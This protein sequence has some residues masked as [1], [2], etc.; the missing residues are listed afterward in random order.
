MPVG[1]IFQPTERWYARRDGRRPA[2]AFRFEWI[3]NA[4]TEPETPCGE[5]V[6]LLLYLV[7]L[8]ILIFLLGAWSAVIVPALFGALVLNRESP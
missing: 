3:W 2:L 7:E 8:W 5:P 6:L 1:F 4:A